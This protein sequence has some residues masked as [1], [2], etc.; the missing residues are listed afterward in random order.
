MNSY[1]FGNTRYNGLK[2][3]CHRTTIMLLLSYDNIERNIHDGRRATSVSQ[4]TWLESIQTQERE[5]KNRVSLCS[6]M[7]SWRCLSRT[8]LKARGNYRGSCSKAA[9]KGSVKYKATVI[10]WQRT[11]KDSAAFRA[12][13]TRLDNSPKAPRYSCATFSI[14]ACPMASQWLYKRVVRVESVYTPMKRKF[15]PFIKAIETKYDGYKFRSRLEARWATFFNA[16]DIPYAYE[17][18][19]YDLEGVWYLPDFWLPSLDCWIEIKGKEPTEEERE[20]TQLLA[21]YTQKEVCTFYGNIDLPELMDFEYNSF[22][23]RPARLW[24]YLKSEGM[25]GKGPSTTLVEIPSYI[26][27]LLQKIHDN[28]LNIYVEERENILIIRSENHPYAVDSIDDLTYSLQQ[29]INTLEDLQEYLEEHEKEIRKALTPEDGWEIDFF[30][31]LNGLED[32]CIW[33]E[34]N[35]CGALQ[36][37]SGF[38]YTHQCNTTTQGTFSHNTPR[39]IAAYEAARQARF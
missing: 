11:I 30:P 22:L 19:G 27:A 4:R 14:T 16:L 5:E 28:D 23:D 18:E 34:C 17:H 8:C 36:I 2:N 7:A 39:L 3:P 15:N 25:V 24:K 33:S 37:K 12:I 31:Q 9:R 20:K 26:L 35:S 10:R 38:L 21:L 29:Q 1:V 6:E 32:I 13:W